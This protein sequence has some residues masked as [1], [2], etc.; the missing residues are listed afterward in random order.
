MGYVNFVTK[1]WK[2]RMMWKYIKNYN[3]GIEPIKNFNV[4]KVANEETTG[5]IE[6]LRD[7][8]S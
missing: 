5:Q 4:G 8:H 2:K 6:V 7:W 3:I 1:Q